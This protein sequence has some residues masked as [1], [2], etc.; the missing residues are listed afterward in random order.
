MYHASFTQ[1][2]VALTEFNDI[3]KKNQKKRLCS[4]KVLQT[5]QY[6]AKYCLEISNY[7]MTTLQNRFWE[8]ILTC[9][10]SFIWNQ[11]VLGWD[12]YFWKNSLL[13]NEECFS[14]DGVKHNI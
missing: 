10:D 7:V 8:Y 4:D 3:K 13:R 2:S 5:S 9:D 12:F 11:D 1:L 14:F 6:A